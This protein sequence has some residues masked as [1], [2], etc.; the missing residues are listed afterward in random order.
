MSH[1]RPRW[2]RNLEAQMLESKIDVF[3]HTFEVFLSPDV[4]YIGPCIEVLDDR[5]ASILCASLLPPTTTF[6]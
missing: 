1:L 4:S 5:I 2:A 6:H 3:L